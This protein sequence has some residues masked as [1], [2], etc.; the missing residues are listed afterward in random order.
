MAAKYFTNGS[1]T[2]SKGAGITLE[3][4]SVSEDGTVLAGFFEPTAKLA[5]GYLEKEITREEYEIWKGRIANP[6]MV[7]FFPGVFPGI[8]VVDKATYEAIQARRLL[9]QKA[10]RQVTRAQ[11]LKALARKGI[12]KQV[13]YAAI[14][15]LPVDDAIDAR[16][17]FDE[18]T[19][20][21]RSSNLVK[22]MGQSLGMT[23][24]QLDELFELALTL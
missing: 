16:I 2:D 8:G 14:D 13:I 15:A 7:E 10:N 19:T 3:V 11:G 18:Q 23:P 1:L 20:W 4:Q 21:R 5:E 9:E 6:D 24:D 17:D 12:T 22:A